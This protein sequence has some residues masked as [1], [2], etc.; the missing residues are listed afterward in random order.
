MK[1]IALYQ[2]IHRTKPRLSACPDSITARKP[3]GNPSHRTSERPSTLEEVV[4]LTGNWSGSKVEE[5]GR[6]A[7]F[8]FQLLRGGESCCPA[9]SLS[10][11]TNSRAKTRNS[12]RF[13]GATI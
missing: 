6:T 3:S 7:R 5:R 12:R 8:L 1:T 9:P 4:E 10:I 13:L 11:K 2:L